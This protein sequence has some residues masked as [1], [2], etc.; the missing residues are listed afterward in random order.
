VDEVNKAKQRPRL[1]VTASSSI[2]GNSDMLR[3][4]LD[5]SFTDSERPTP[6]FT[7]STDGAIYE[8]CATPSTMSLY[9]VGDHPEGQAVR[10]PLMT[11]K[12]SISSMERVTEESALPLHT[13]SERTGTSYTDISHWRDDFITPGKVRLLRFNKQG[14][15][16]V[17]HLPSDTVGGIKLLEYSSTR[18][19]TVM[20]ASADLN[21]NGKI[22]LKFLEPRMLLMRQSIERC[23]HRCHTAYKHRLAAAAP[24]TRSG[25]WGQA[26]SAKSDGYLALGIVFDG[27]A[28]ICLHPGVIFG[29]RSGSMYESRKLILNA[30]ALDSAYFLKIPSKASSIVLALG[31]A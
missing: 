10:T 7:P 8:E 13:P 15:R 9:H 21:Q 16:V 3:S 29:Q 23:I 11:N 4:A 26:A 2:D 20:Y 25:Y 28:K 24:S 31:S 17:V 27:L 30:L 18:F 22:F 12:H 19:R 5:S 1:T 6:R 14:R